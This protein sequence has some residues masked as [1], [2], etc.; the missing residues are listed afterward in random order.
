MWTWF[1][2]TRLGRALIW[3]AVG[4]AILLSLVASVWRAAVV[5]TR[6]K[7]AMKRLETYRD[8][9]QSI[10]KADV[11]TGDSDV[12]RKWLEERSKR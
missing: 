2:G 11:S 4:A 1:L 8:T 12:D 9:R 3:M 10:D 6:H 5:S 7:E